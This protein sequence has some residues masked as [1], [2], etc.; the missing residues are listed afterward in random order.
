VLVQIRERL[1]IV[2]FKFEESDP[3]IRHRLTP[4]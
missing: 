2:P 1:L 3:Q 4:P